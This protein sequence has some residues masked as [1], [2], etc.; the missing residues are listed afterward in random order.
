MRPSSGYLKKPFDAKLYEENDG[1][2]KDAVM[3]YVFRRWDVWPVDGTQYGVDIEIYKDKLVGY[4]EV[5]RRHNWTDD[6][7]YETVHVPKRKLKFFNLELPTVLFSVRSDLS[8]ALWC[9][10]DTI[11]HSPTVNSPNKY[12]K[13][14]EFFSVPIKEWSLVNL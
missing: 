8:Q 2:A 5:E 7:P 10:G 14:E 9:R 13:E 1:P 11:K 6:W 12:M 3:S 4:I